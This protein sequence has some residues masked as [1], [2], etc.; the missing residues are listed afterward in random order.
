MTQAQTTAAQRLADAREAL[1][2]VAHQ[3]DTLEARHEAEPDNWG[4]VGVMGHILG[5][6]ETIANNK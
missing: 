4:L 3:L 1:A 5:R 6:L 2:T